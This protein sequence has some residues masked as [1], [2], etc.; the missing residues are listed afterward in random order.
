MN[1]HGHVDVAIE[2]D[3]ISIGCEIS[4]STDVEHEAGNLSKCIAA[5]FDYAVIVSSEKKTL[6]LAKTLFEKD[7][8]FGR[9]RF[10]TPDGFI[11]FLD[12][13]D[14]QAQS[15]SQTVRGYKVNVKY[16]AVD[17]KDKKD[18]ER[19]LADVISQSLR[20]TKKRK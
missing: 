11:A 7:A 3:G 19:M 17:E 16:R 18:R 4:V 13:L 5:G 14:A 20:R 12:E 10:L 9:M 8:A 6:S 15:T 1:G 2:R